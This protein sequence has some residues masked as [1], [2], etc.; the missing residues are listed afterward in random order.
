MS[1]ICYSKHELIESIISR[2]LEIGLHDSE[3]FVRATAARAAKRTEM[4]DF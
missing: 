3:P 2:L 1:E 4:T